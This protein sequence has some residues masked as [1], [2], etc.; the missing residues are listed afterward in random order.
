MGCGRGVGVRGVGGVVGVVCGLA[1]VGE[2]LA[3][4]AVV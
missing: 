1:W 3:V 2:G 4:G